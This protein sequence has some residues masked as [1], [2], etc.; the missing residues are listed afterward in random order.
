MK[1]GITYDTKEDY[2]NI[3]YSRYCDFASLTSISFLKK[4]FEQAGFETQLIGSYK[5]LF[6]LVKR[7]ELDV[8]FIYNTAEGLASRNRE[9]FIPSLLEANGIPY[10]GSDSYAL[11]LTL[12]KY[13]TKLLAQKNHIPTPNAE[14]IYLYDSDEIILHKLQNLHCPLIIKPNYEGSSMGL[15]YAET[16]TD[17]LAYIKQDL[18]IYNQEILCEEFI[19]GIEVTVPV[20]GNHAETKALGCVEFYRGDGNPI[21]IFESDDKHYKDIRCREVSLPEEITSLLK[22][23]SVLLHRFIGCHDIDRVDYRITS[24]YHIYFLEMNPLPALD[25]EGSFVC[26]ARSQGMD[27]SKILNLLVQYAKERYVQ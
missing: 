15:F 10:I 20:I 2:E 16:L 26:A 23:Y 13:H 7:D 24:D 22:G 12:N 8:D 9:G 18:K 25:P 14:L 19:D 1:I 21:F 11:S 4:Q 6:N 17:A 3:D 5:K 27:F